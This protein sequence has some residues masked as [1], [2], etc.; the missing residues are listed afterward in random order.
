MRNKKILYKIS[1]SSGILLSGLLLYAAV[2]PPEY[3]IQ[4]EVT[5]KAN[6]ETIFP[7]LVNTKSVD[8]WMPWK[9][10]DPQVKISYSGPSEGIG[11][12]SSW[13]SPGQMGVG[14]A[15]VIEVIPNQLV[16]TKITYTKPMA[17]TQVSKFLLTPGNG[18]TIMRWSVVGNNS[19]M[20]R[21]VCLF[22]NMDKHVGT[23]FESGLSKLKNLVETQK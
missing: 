6:P 18:E 4:R 11:A 10:T 5:I 19:F 1:I 21:F 3:L 2:Q 16:S 13:E 17:F 12:I 23:Q 20:G 9:D 7:H 15:E 14:Q 22:M 8:E